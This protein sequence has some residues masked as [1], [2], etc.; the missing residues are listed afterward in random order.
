MYSLLPQAW[1]FTPVWGAAVEAD[2]YA[3]NRNLPFT[4][5][6]LGKPSRPETGY[7]YIAA[8]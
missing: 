4:H 1:I 3:R 6:T 8:A 7:G 2:L 5:K